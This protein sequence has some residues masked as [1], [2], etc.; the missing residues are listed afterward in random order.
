MP[1][2]L[3]VSRLLCVVHTH[4]S[5]VLAVAA[6]VM[7]VLA[8]RSL[9]SAL[10]GRAVPARSAKHAI[11][12]FDRLLGNAKLFAD[13]ALFYGAICTAL[14]TT[15]QPTIL[16]DWTC[17]RGRW[18][19][20]T[21]SLALR[22]RSLPLLSEVHDV[23]KLGNPK[24]HRAF[25][26]RLSSLLPSCS[27]VIVSDAGFHGDFFR[28][29]LAL[30][31]NFVG[32]IRGTAQLRCGGV[33]RTKKSLYASATKRPLDLPG[34]QLYAK[35]S[36]DCRLIL[37]RRPHAKR[38]SKPTKN[39]EMIAYRK[40][41]RDPWLLATSLSRDTAEQVVALYAARM[42]I[43][44]TFRDIKSSAFGL[45]LNETRSRSRERI[46]IQLMLAALA[47]TVAVLVGIDAE[48]RNEQYALQANTMRAQRVLSL[49]RL[50]LECVTRAILVVST[51]S[52]R[53]DLSRLRLIIR[54]DL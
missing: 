22:G 26:R 28:T 50:G 32:R 36:I 34:S 29:V 14:I 45:R 2:G 47:L 9:S 30:G 41:A 52:L 23:T 39:K 4:K 42:Q 37:V 15:R 38:R 21:A 8:A 17:V 24:V 1:V 20:L 10:M 27:P 12:R 43:E 53:E 11:K 35:M 6:G 19:A 48:S 51:V 49:V 25:L 33:P 54:G 5:R 16:V 44:E 18:H 13:L 40:A 31:W 3:I 46:S 7:G